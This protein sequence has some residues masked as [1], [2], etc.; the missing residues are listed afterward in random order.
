MTYNRLPRKDPRTIA[1]EIPG[2]LEA[3][4]PQLTAG[5]VTY[6]NHR[7]LGYK[8]VE[9]VSEEL[10]QKSLLRHAMLFELAY[11]RAEEI[12]QG[13][14]APDWQKCLELAG[15]RQRRH[16]DAKIPATIAGVDAE[17]AEHVAQNLVS[18]LR[19]RLSGEQ[20]DVIIPSPRI[21]GFQWIAS[22]NGDFSIDSILIEVKCSNRNFGSADYRQVL[23]YWLLSYAA[24]VN[25]TG[26]EWKSIL[27]LNPR[28]NRYLELPFD[29]LIEITAAGKSKIEILE[30]FTSQVDDYALRS[31]PEFRM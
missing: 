15:K 25:E 29:E 9:S 20:S 11:T 22:G 27:L 2:L 21:P 24:S 3:V 16:F 6:L 18:T 26:E 10:I 30:L 4:F 12:L 28:K 23:I 13:A 1:R 5:V 17:I 19:H 8:N 14:N 31:L 7:M